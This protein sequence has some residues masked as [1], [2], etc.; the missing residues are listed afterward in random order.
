MIENKKY[1]SR[2]DD[3]E[4]RKW[5]YLGYGQK[6]SAPIHW[7]IWPEKD[8]SITVAAPYEIAIFT[9]SGGVALFEGE[10]ILSAKDDW[11]A[12]WGCLSYFYTDVVPRLTIPKR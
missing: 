12:I 10:T 4:L 6:S 5:K 11:E 7:R 9:V 8:Q 3:E 2:D 1:L